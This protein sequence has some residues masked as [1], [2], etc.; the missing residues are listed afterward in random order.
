[1]A[2]AKQFT[3]N[4]TRWVWSDE[5]NAYVGGYLGPYIKKIEGGKWVM[6]KSNGDYRTDIPPCNTAYDVA[7]LTNP[8]R[9]W[10]AITG[11]GYHRSD[12]LPL[13][14]R[15]APSPDPYS[16]AYDI[17]DIVTDRWYGRDMSTD[18]LTLTKIID[19]AAHGWSKH[20]TKNI[21]T[22]FSG[23]TIEHDMSSNTWGNYLGFHASHLLYALKKSQPKHKRERPKPGRYVANR[24]LLSDFEPIRNK[25]LNVYISNP[26][27]G[28]TADELREA[29]HL[30]NQWAEYLDDA[31]PQ[32]PMPA[33]DAM[34]A[35]ASELR[36]FIRAELIDYA[37]NHR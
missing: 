6:I 30:F 28:M 7:V 11:G 9:E 5:K 17:F 3:C 16:K 31:Q 34:P 23:L 22:H 10:I 15:L 2:D 12:G 21:L 27:K 18:P 14:V 8:T 36:E 24:I 25:A 35:T 37:R 26:H 1:M 13:I 32:Q 20:S 33:P 4:G 19:N 29:A